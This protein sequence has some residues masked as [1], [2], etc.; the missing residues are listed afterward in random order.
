MYDPDPFEATAARQ[1]RVDERARW[2]RKLCK[3]P[4]M[5]YH[6]VR[7]DVPVELFGSIDWDGV[8]LAMRQ[9]LGLLPARLPAIAAL[10]N[11]LNLGGSWDPQQRLSDRRRE[12][13]RAQGMSTRTVMRLEEEGAG[14]ISELIDKVYYVRT[15]AHELAQGAVYFTLMHS[16]QAP[17][18]FRREELV[19]ALELVRGHRPRPVAA[20]DG[21]APAPACHVSVALLGREG[22]G[23]VRL[24]KLRSKE[25]TREWLAGLDGMEFEVEMWE[26]IHVRWRAQPGRHRVEVLDVEAFN[27]GQRWPRLGAWLAAP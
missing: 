5:A 14:F 25:A 24:A 15:P 6:R 10:G 3:G 20:V 19:Q 8:E 4:G 21:P 18:Y 17:R 27:A 11:A 26:R 23:T 22:V 12:Y 1:A 16:D 7:A 13:A 2:I 9:S